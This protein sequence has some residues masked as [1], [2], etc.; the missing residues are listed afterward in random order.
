MNWKHMV[1]SQFGAAIDALENAMRLCPDRLWSGRSKW[2]D[3]WY[4][5]F[6]TLFWLDYYLEDS[7]EDYK[8]IP[9][10]TLSEL[11]PAGIVPDPP[12]TKEQLLAYLE[13][14]RDKCKAY[15]ERMTDEQA[16]S[17]CGRDRLD[18]TRGELLLYSLRHVQHHAAQ[19]NL[20][21]RQIID[22]AP[23]WTF[24]SKD[25]E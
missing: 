20:L 21:L 16:D 1:W 3:I 5:S 9:P 11:D 8:P 7:A 2:Y 22:D 6:H 14:G 4:I 15:I 19:L 25:L 23:G 17:P 18:L 13:H 10:Y 24:K 12:Y